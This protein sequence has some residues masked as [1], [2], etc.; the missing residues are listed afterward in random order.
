ML[1][2]F[3]PGLQSEHKL[4]RAGPSLGCKSGGAGRTERLVPFSIQL[5]ASSFKWVQTGSGVARCNGQ[6]V[7]ARAELAHHDCGKMR[8]WHRRGHVRQP[9]PESEG[10]PF[11]SRRRSLYYS[12]TKGEICDPAMIQPRFELLLPKQR[13]ACVAMCQYFGS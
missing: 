8:R 12:T 10:I 2:Q 7:V 1:L 3:G 9:P 6:V 11:A 13:C 4:Q 5:A